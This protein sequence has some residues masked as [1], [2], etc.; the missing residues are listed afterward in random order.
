ME[1][2]SRASP[3]HR[4]VSWMIGMEWAMHS[5]WRRASYSRA[6]WMP[7]KEFMFLISTFVPSFVSP[8]GRMEMFTSERMLPSSRLQSL[9][10]A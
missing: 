2:V 3:S 1:A 7:R 9:T 4:R 8:T 10:P 5:R 6:A